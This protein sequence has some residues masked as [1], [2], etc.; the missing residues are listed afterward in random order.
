[1]GELMAIWPGR[2]GTEWATTPPGAFCFFVAEVE[3]GARWREIVNKRKPSGLRTSSLS[4]WGKG[5]PQMLCTMTIIAGTN[6]MSR[7]NHLSNQCPSS[8]PSR[9]SG[10]TADHA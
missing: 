8:R 9:G 3:R 7:E 2:W 10:E 5:P 1:M 4:N 6:M